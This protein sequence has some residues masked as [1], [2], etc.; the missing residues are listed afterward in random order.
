VLVVAFSPDG[1]RFVS[2]GIDFTA[3]VWDATSL[4]AEILQTQDARYQ[5]KRQALAELARAVEDAQL[6][7]NL[8]KSGQRNLS[9]AAFGKF[10]EQDPDHLA[11]RHAQILALLEANDIAAARRACEALRKRSANTTNLI[12]GTNGVWSCVLTPDA[13]AEPGALVRLAELAL[14]DTPEPGQTRSDWLRTLGAAL[15]RAGRFAEAI[16]S[17]EES[18]Q[19]RGDQG[20]PKGLGHFLARVSRPG[21]RLSQDALSQSYGG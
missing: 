8:A 4:P 1:R 9:A 11:R 10:T 6:A 14:R 7:D 12:L 21:A 16:R 2:G 13:V 3:R 19:N 5:R 17:L 15:Y 20:D 18:N